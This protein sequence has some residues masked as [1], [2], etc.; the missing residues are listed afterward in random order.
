M[1]GKR[2]RKNDLASLPGTREQ[3]AGILNANVNDLGALGNALKDAL[4]TAIGSKALEGVIVEAVDL[5]KAADDVVRDGE[6][7]LQ[8]RIR[9]R[10]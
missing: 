1:N 10:L 5:K 4:T 8:V 9:R 6:A 2:Q 3:Q 7:T